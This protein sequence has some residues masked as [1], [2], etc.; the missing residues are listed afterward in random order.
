MS[1]INMYNENIKHNPLKTKEDLR[2]ALYDICNPL[3]PLLKEQKHGHLCLGTSGSVYDENAREVE[4]FLRPLWGIG[5]LVTTKSEEGTKL[6]KY[7][8][9]GLIEGTDPK[10]KSYFGKVHDYDQL[11]VEMASVSLSLILA[12]IGRAH[13]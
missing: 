12:K 1:E 8:V 11:L 2:K 10:S 6:S 13:V 9:E 7:F 3:I 5:P 4:A